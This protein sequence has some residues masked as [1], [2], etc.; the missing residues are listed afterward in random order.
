MRLKSWMLTYH[1]WLGWI[2]IIPWAFVISSGLLL[3]VRYE[4]PWVEPKE[5]DAVIDELDEILPIL[6][7]LH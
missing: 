5:A 4:L 6:R 7:R 3:Q 2:V 1:Y